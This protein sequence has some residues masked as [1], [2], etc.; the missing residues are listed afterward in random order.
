MYFAELSID[1]RVDSAKPIDAE[2]PSCS[3]GAVSEA[4]KDKPVEAVNHNGNIGAETSPKIESAQHVPDS[5]P[6]SVASTSAPLSQDLSAMRHSASDSVVYRTDVEIASS[7]D[8]RP[9]CMQNDP[10][11]GS[12]GLNGY[13]RTVE[14][15]QVCLVFRCTGFIVHWPL[16][17]PL[18]SLVAGGF[19]FPGF[20]GCLSECPESL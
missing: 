1:N 10:V 2:R 14:E 11:T 6:V 12:A 13:C 9:D 5:L 19:V 8:V 20:S 18:S 17:V 3:D 4:V 15:T 16:F 7:C